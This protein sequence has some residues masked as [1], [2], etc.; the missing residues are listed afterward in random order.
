MEK[1]LKQWWLNT[2]KYAE[3]TFFHVWKLVYLIT[4]HFFIYF[5]WSI[6]SA[7]FSTNKLKHVYSSLLT[8]WL[9]NHKTEFRGKMGIKVDIFYFLS[10]WWSVWDNN[11]ITFILPK[12]LDETASVGTVFHLLQ[13][14]IITSRQRHLRNALPGVTQTWTICICLLVDNHYNY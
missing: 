13:T 14:N 6:V 1:T 4:D 11:L 5:V 12:A 10:H 7:C 9:M 3:C 2:L 8:S